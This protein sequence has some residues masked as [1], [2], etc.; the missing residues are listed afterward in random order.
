[1]TLRSSDLQSVSDLDSIRNSCDVL[2]HTCVQNHVYKKDMKYYQA[3]LHNF[4]LW[5]YRFQHKFTTLSCTIFDMFLIKGKGGRL[6]GHPGQLYSIVKLWLYQQPP[7]ESASTQDL[8]VLSIN[9][10]SEGRQGRGFFIICISTFN[11]FLGSFI[12]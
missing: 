4:K 12:E 9:V 7:Y 8:R 6:L 10:Q 5:F 2:F 1:M 3:T 11:T